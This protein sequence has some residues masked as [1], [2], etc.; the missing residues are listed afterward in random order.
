VEAAC[1]SNLPSETICR[2]ARR[3]QAELIVIGPPRHGAFHDLMLG[4]TAQELLKHAPCPILIV[5]ASAR[6]PRGLAAGS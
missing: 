1:S 5:P 2:E 4:S 3:I 6:E